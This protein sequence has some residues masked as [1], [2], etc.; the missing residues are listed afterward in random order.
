MSGE[1]DLKRFIE[2]TKRDP[3]LARQLAQFGVEKWGD[4]HLPLDID[5][6]KVI[7]LAR[8]HGYHFDHSDV[9]RSQCEQL[10]SFWMFEMEN[11]FVA[12]R[13]M[14][15]IQLRIHRG[16]IQLPGIDYYKY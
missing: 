12:R 14:S 5:I 1:S 6:S 7:E 11:S 10:Q 3:E 8:S 4:A 9:F 16:R 2:H 13:Y 15:R